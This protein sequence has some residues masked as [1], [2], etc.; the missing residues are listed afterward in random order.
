MTARLGGGVCSTC[1]TLSS[2]T[3]SLAMSLEST[4]KQNNVSE[5]ET[6]SR[7]WEGRKVRWKRFFPTWR[8]ERARKK[9]KRKESQFPPSE[10][11]RDDWFRFCIP[12][13]A[14]HRFSGL[15]RTLLEMA[16]RTS[17]VLEFSLL[18]LTKN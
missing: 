3:F 1:C 8:R 14:N 15:T 7:E 10:C 2:T 4:S 6:V 12:T 17:A 16:S 5:E 9:E 18:T 13:S 11:N